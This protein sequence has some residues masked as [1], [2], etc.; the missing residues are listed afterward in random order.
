MTGEWRR[1]VVGPAYLFLC[2]VLGGSAQGIWGN[3]VLQMLGILI[4]A[5][6]LLDPSR[7]P[8]TR[9]SKILVMILG[10][11]IGLALVQLIPLPPAIWTH[12]PGRE[13]IAD[14]RILLGLPSGWGSISLTPY[15][16]VATLLSLLPPAAL[17]LAIASAGG[18]NDHWL[19]VALAVATLG[20]S[21]LGLLQ[22]SSGVPAQS[23][24][25]LYKVSNFGFAT[26]F[27]ANSNH[28]ASQ[29]LATLPFVAALALSAAESSK[30]GR[31]RYSLLTLGAGGIG[32]LIVGLALN[33]SLAGAGLLL[34]VA[35]AVLLM[36]L[37]VSR[38]KTIAVTG[39]GIL[40]LGG[41]LGLLF[42]PLGD[43]IALTGASTSIS[44]RQDILTHSVQAIKEFGPVGSGLGSYAKIYP[45]FEDADSVDR[46]WV[47]HAHNDY[48]ELAVELGAP[49][50]LL[51][52]I[53]LLWWASAVFQMLA[54]PNASLFAKAGAIG[55]TAILLHSVVDFP[56]RT[57]A[58]SSL[59]ALCLAMILLSRRSAATNNDLR[60][61]R[62]LV[63]E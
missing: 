4:I 3:A 9:S 46:T 30:D 49:G 39:L 22:V 13:F 10:A 36:A 29:L 40:A 34:P 18:K 50:I 5:N 57:S 44:T 61:V 15:D 52:I 37:R 20:G 38:F 2:L 43:R 14:G 60:E 21:I 35:M 41:F 33:G 19:A 26:G 6:C 11:A 53:F 42:T 56:L 54:T 58:I 25:Y 48:I 16:T 55:S 17:F 62:H 28:M 59:F 32:V 45:L 24:W 47:N 12:L 27:F 31:K 51:T 23:P 63:I 7:P 8:F 1:N